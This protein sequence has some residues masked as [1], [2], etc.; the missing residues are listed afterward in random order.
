MLNQDT[1]RTKAVYFQFFSPS[2]VEE[3]DKQAMK[4]MHENG[5]NFRLEAQF[6]DGK[7]KPRWYDFIVRYLPWKKR[8]IN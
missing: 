4:I 5:G 1:D 6:E 8:I 3:L 2:W 7:P